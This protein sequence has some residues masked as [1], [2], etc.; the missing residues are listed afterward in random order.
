MSGTEGELCHL[1]TG[2]SKYRHWHP[3]NVGKLPLCR[4]SH[5]NAAVK[6]L[7]SQSKQRKH[8]SDD[9]GAGRSTSSCNLDACGE[10]AGALGLHTPSF[11]HSN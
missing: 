10:D 11:N 4:M 3:F 6:T 9:A 1:L 8:R 5:Y 7:K 2:C